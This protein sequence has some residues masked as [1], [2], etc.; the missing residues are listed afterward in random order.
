MYLKKWLFS[1]LVAGV[2]LSGCNDSNV[3]YVENNVPS[4]SDFNMTLNVNEFNITAEWEIASSSEDEDNDTLSAKVLTQGN[5]GHFDI[6]GSTITYTKTQETNASDTGTIEITDGSDAVQ[7]TVTVHALYWI[8]VS[9]G[10]VHTSA[11]K[12]DGTLW[13]WGYNSDGQLGDGTTINQSSPVQE[14][15]HATD[16]VQVSAGG[17]HTTAIKNNGTLWSWGKN[18]YGQ[19]GDGTTI[20]QSSPVQ[21]ATHAADW[22]QVSAGGN[23]TAAIKNNGTL[24]SW[25]NNS[26]GELGDGTTT[27]QNSPVQ[28]ATHGTDWVQVSTGYF[29]TAAVKSNGTLWSWGYNSYGQLGDGTITHQSS[30]VQEATH[31][32]DW[33]QVSARYNHTAAVKSNGTLWSWGYNSYGQLGDSTTI[34]RSSPVQE[35][36]HAA[37]WIQVSAGYF[38]TAAIKSGGTLWSWGDN[39]FGQLGDGTNA[40]SYKPIP[41]NDDSNWQQISAGYYHTTAIKSD[42]TLWSWGRNS[43]GQLGDGTTVNKNAPIKIGRTIEE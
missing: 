8:Q 21:E 5:Y 19:L 34:N 12:S 17:H 40:S 6:N 31:A 27:R 35:A 4:A 13:S 25:G 23:Y 32:T 36:T 11:V 2:F 37:D 39:G 28:E 1:L 15:T 18:Y 9:A 3:H 38:H 14:A 16:W 42:G 43:E 22:V 41:V 10:G 33:V 20:N 30:L 29:H 24:W 26:Y 7:V